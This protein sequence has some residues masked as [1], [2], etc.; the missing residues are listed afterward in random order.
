MLLRFVG[1]ATSAF[2]EP[3]LAAEVVILLSWQKFP[4]CSY[5]LRSF[6]RKKSQGGGRIINRDQKEAVH[7]FPFSL[8]LQIIRSFRFNKEVDHLIASRHGRYYHPLL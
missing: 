5:S 6:H 7:P 2:L 8:L 1:Q 4:L 3:G